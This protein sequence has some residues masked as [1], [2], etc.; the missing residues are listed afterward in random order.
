MSLMKII[1]WIAWVFTVAEFIASPIHVLRGSAV[2]LQRFREVNFPLSW[3]RGLAVLELLG[4]ATV[5]IGLWVPLARLI[6]GIVLAAAFLPLL[7]WAAKAKRP[8]TDLLGLAFFMAC[9]LIVS[10]Y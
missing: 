5:I 2:H 1:F 10:L 3:A 4:V 9:A 6:G 8:A 7:L